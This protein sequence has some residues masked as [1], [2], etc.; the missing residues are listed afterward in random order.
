MPRFINDDVILTPG[1]LIAHKITEKQLMAEILKNCSIKTKIKD[2]ADYSKVIRSCID[3]MLEYNA[4]YDLDDYDELHL[5]S[6]MLIAEDN[7]SR[8]AWE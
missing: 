3:G 2:K 7:T 4:G 1:A 6:T 5:T 8:M